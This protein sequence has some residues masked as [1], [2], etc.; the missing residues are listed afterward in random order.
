M[1][2]LQEPHA[3]V[4]LDHPA[5]AI[6]HETGVDYATWYIG[7]KAEQ[8]A[9]HYGFAED[10]DEDIRQEL[11][12]HLLQQW[13]AFDPNVAKATTFIQNVIDF[14]VCELIRDQERQKRDYR[15]EEPLTDE[16][17]CG[18]LDGTRGQPEVSDYDLIALRADCE[19]IIASLPRDLRQLAELLKETSP[20]DAA[21]RMQLPLMTVVDRIDELRER[22][23][24]GGYGEI[25]KS[26][27]T[28]NE[29][30]E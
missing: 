11:L 30:N 5:F 15:R 8:L 27:V 12:L 21:R 25:T 13:P 18:L 24:A 4:A 9:G 19:T 1:P 7:R 3:F 20:S 2:A 10:E 28:N 23:I 16:A 6:L 17:E 14:K 26:D 22:F 29:E